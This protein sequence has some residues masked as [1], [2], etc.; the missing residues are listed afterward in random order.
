M[1]DV[2]THLDLYAN[3]ILPM[4][5][6]VSKKRIGKKLRK[7]YDTARTPLTR[8]I[9][10]GVM[11]S[12]MTQRLLEIEHYLLRSTEPVK[13]KSTLDSTCSAPFFRS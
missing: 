8:L 1:N 13:G 5:K 3:M 11:T 7:Q 4:R 12:E 9:E 6:V 10:A 2:Y